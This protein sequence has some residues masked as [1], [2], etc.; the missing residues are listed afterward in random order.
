MELRRLED[1]GNLP[2]QAELV[3]ATMAAVEVVVQAAVV[4]TAALLAE[5]DARRHSRRQLF[6]HMDERHG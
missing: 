1:G 3:C 6:T 2:L 4:V 5:H